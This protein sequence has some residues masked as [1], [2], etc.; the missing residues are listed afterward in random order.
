[1]EHQKAAGRNEFRR[2]LASLKEHGLL[3]Q[4]D[5]RLPNVCALVTGV[6]VRGSW[7]AHPRS[8][9]IFRMN[10]GLAEHPDALVIKLVS[11]KVTY[12]D[13]ALWSAVVAVGR[14]RATWQLERLSRA[15][16]DLLE[17]VDRAPVQTDRRLAKPASELEKVLLIYS[18]QFHTAAGS[19]TRRLE[20]WDRWLQ[21]KGFVPAELS[22]NRP[23]PKAM[24]KAMDTLERVMESL[25]HRFNACGRLPWQA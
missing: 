24:A 9:D 14:A 19:H 5:A 7:W 23:R 21:R 25:N 13:R 18:E 10:C 1:M 3:L 12:V 2:V 4:T 17:E 16:R 8:H 15:A 20:S 6:P 22:P 11:A